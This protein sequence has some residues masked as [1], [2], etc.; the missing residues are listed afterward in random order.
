M[1]RGTP[2]EDVGSDLKHAGAAPGIQLLRERL[3]ARRPLALRDAPATRRAAVL[4][5]I[6]GSD[7]DLSLLLFQ[8]THSVL[9]HKGEIC[10]PGGSIEAEDRNVTDAALREAHEELGLQRADV[11]LLGQ[12]DDVHTIAS[13]YII[14]PV[15]GH[16]TRMPELIC[17]PLEVERPVVVSLR[18]LTAPGACG[19][20]WLEWGGVSRLRYYYDVAGGRI[21]GATA[22]MLHELLEVWF[23]VR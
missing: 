10:F 16:L 22:R 6:V 21:W 1:A 12:L 7:D 3:A 23:G 5:P 15:V 17:D 19:T 14:T 11:T 13:S 18:E 9:E 4:V 8:R 2:S 20:Q